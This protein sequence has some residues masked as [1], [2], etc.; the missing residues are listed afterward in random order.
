MSKRNPVYD[1]KWCPGCG[2]F[3]VKRAIEGAI[4]QRVT[5][6][7]QPVENNVVVAGIG[8]SG[9]LVHLQEGPQP[10]GLHGIH[11]R[12]LP[13]AWGIKSSNPALNVMVV[14]G[15]GDFL[16]I[17]AE[18]IGAQAKRNADITAVVM[19]N[20]VYGLTKGQA[21]PTTAFEAITPTTPYGKLDD[22]TNPLV[23]YLA[24]GVSFIASGMSSQVKALQ[25]MIGEAMAF[26]G[27][28]IV[29]VQSPCTT[30]NDTYAQLK[31]DAKNGVEPVAF[32]LP[33]DHDPADY[34]SA[35]DYAHGSRIPL[36]LLYQKPDSVS[37][38]QRLGRAQE[39]VAAPSHS[40]DGLLT[41]MRI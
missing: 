14:S 1:F 10:F 32:A 28:S 38:H 26:P 35:L 4:A 18:H 12:A 5:E 8:C 34:K 39:L 20:G 3:G 7:G 30:Y 9:N 13:I 11:G 33:E 37:A 41:G 6:L 31:G 22:P 25:Q 21:S 23:T 2:D 29:H 17:G 36:G 16:S 40:V 24:A 15:D 27:F 19:D